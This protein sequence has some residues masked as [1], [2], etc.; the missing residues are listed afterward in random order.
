MDSNDLTVRKIHRE[1]YKALKKQVSTKVS[2]K[3]L[4]KCAEI[5][6]KSTFELKQ[7]SSHFRRTRTDVDKIVQICRSHFKQRELYLTSGFTQDTQ[8]LDPSD[9]EDSFDNQLSESSTD[10]EI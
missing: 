9:S 6:P 8:L 2:S 5:L 7:I 4:R 1:C 10:G 3:L